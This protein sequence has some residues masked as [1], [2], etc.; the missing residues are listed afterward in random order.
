M[1][2]V[3]ITVPVDT[4]IKVIRNSKMPVDLLRLEA[5]SLNSNVCHHHPF[6]CSVNVDEAHTLLSSGHYSSYTLYDLATNFHLQLA[7]LGTINVVAPAMVLCSD[8]H[9]NVCSYGSDMRYYV[10]IGRA[11]V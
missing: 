1:H 3:A 4:G 6:E 11:H 7:T 9:S 5:V 10:E 8:L 2:N